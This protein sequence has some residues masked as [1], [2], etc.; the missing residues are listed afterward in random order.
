V[1][2]SGEEVR[3]LAREMIL[4]ALLLFLVILGVPFAAG[5]YTGRARHRP[6]PRQD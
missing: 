6:R 2:S 4:L 5:Y 1:R 3:L